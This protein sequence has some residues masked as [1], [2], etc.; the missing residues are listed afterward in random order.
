LEFDLPQFT[1]IKNASA[2]TQV[3]QPI[4]NPTTEDTRKPDWTHWG[5]V[6]FVKVWEASLLSLNLNPRAFKPVE[7]PNFSVPDL[8]RET[9]HFGQGTFVSKSQ[10]LAYD[11]RL[12]LIKDSLK[13]PSLITVE[14]TINTNENYWSLNFHEWCVWALENSIAIPDELQDIARSNI[15]QSGSPVVSPGEPIVPADNSTIDHGTYSDS[16]WKKVARAIGQKLYREDSKQGLEKISAKV[17]LEL[18][19]RNQEGQPATSG[20]GGKFPTAG[21]IRRHTLQRLEK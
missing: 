8:Y 16:A 1:G 19:R 6:R 5:H 7:W 9:P 13:P 17:L 21:T 14:L 20:R 3:M 15:P 12:A 2:Y 11:N 10:R 18:I 4:N